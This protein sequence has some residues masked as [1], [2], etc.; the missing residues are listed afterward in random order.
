[1]TS[2]KYTVIL[3][4]YQL[5]IVRLCFRKEFVFMTR[6]PN[7]PL[8]ETTFYILLVLTNPA[9]GYAIIQEVDRL[10][11]GLV[12]IAAGTMYGAIENLLKLNWIEEIPS[13]DKRRRV[14]KITPTGKEILKL[15]TDRLK[16]LLKLTSDFGY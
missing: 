9:H 14:Y 3:Y 15:E 12:K 16:G 1:M 8:T 5:Y 2:S 6:N 11:N 7:L 10:S 13:E 4:T